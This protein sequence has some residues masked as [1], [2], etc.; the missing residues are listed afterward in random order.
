MDIV[1]YSFFIWSTVNWEPVAVYWSRF[2][3]LYKHKGFQLEHLW[4]LNH[5][6]QITQETPEESYL[7]HSL[8]FLGLNVFG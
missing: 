2:Q 1:V 3:R 6:I 5:R 7:L 8:K 4:I